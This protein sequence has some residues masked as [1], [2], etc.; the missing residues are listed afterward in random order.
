MLGAF[1][2]DLITGF[3]SFLFTVLILSYVIGDNPGFRLAI[4]AFLG[5]SA[6]YIAIVVFRQVIVN[7][8]FLPLASGSIL[9]RLLLAFPL[10]MS[11]LLLGKSS[12]AFEWIGRPVVALLVGVGTASAVAGALLGT[13]FPQVL[14]SAD[15]FDLKSN[16]TL[17]GTAGNFISAV[18]VLLGTVT[19][20][21]YFQFTLF[22]KSGTTGKRGWF[23]HM[24]AVLGQVFIAITLGTIFSGVLL[25]ALTAL[26]D[27][28]QSLVSFIYQLLST[29]ISI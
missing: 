19:T 23:V 24:V 5:V 14:A 10:L 28:A 12:A 16:I 17:F 18:L 2:I 9:E 27:R 26:I 6:G 13:L 25:A 1:Q 15:L 4:H 21:G 7:K 11:L 29:F 22:G 20:L 8:L 3:L